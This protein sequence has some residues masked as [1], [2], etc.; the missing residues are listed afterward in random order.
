MFTSLS[1]VPVHL[2]T[3]LLN[4][5]LTARFQ[6]FL[7]SY[8]TAAISIYI[9]YRRACRLLLNDR[10]GCPKGN[11]CCLVGSAE[12]ASSA[13]REQGARRPEQVVRVAG[14]V[15][16]PRPAPQPGSAG[17]SGSAIPDEPWFLRRVPAEMTVGPPRPAGPGFCRA[18]PGA[19]RGG[20]TTGPPCTSGR[21]G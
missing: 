12:A 19:S 16:L 15:P 1:Y 7:T 9:G 10:P 13:Y 21:C 20:R 2:Y 8:H 11:A 18:I 17:N 4:A 5:N 14:I 6:L 3:Q